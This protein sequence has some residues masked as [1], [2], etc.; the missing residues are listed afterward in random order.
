MVSAA[1]RSATGGTNWMALAPLPT[2]AT[3]LPG[4]V[5]AVVPPGRVPHR[6]GEV[7]EAGKIGYMGTV[8]LTAGEDH[9]VG[10]DL[11]LPAGRGQHQSPPLL[12]LVELGPLHGGSQTQMRSELE[13]VDA[14]FGVGEDLRLVG[15]AA[16]PVGLREKEKEYR[17][18]GT[19]HPLPG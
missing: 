19:S 17:W 3:R 13:P 1:A 4:Q 15:E 7:P 16:G 10:H 18:E 14:P 2:T 8:E 5:A 6:P 9:R 12:G 11:L